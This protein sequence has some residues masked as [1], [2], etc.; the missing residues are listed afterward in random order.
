MNAG[1]DAGGDLG[2]GASGLGDALDHGA[3]LVCREDDLVESEAACFGLGETGFDFVLAEFHGG[4]GV[5]GF[6][7]NGL[8]HAGDLFGGGGGAFGEAADF[9]GDDG[10]TATVL[11]GA[12]GFNGGVEGEEVGLAG[13]F[14]DDAGDAADAFGADAESLD[15]GG[16]LGGSTGGAADDAEGFF[17][18]GLSVAGGGFGLVAGAGCGF[19]GA[20]DS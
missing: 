20:G 9:C 10:E 17:N 2:L 7:L 1:G 18:H 15:G 13:D 5:S 16:G 6:A 14:V 11:A 4:D 8:D 19:G 3:G 12:G